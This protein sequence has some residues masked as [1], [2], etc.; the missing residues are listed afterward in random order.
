MGTWC[1][2]V[3]KDQHTNILGVLEF[4][5]YKGSIKILYFRILPSKEYLFIYRCF[6]TYRQ[7]TEHKSIQYIHQQAAAHSHYNMSTPKDKKDSR[8]LGVKLR[9]SFT[10]S[11]KPRQPV[12][13]TVTGTSA[14]QVKETRKGHI[15]VYVDTDELD[16]NANFVP[17]TSQSPS[18]RRKK[19][20]S[21]KRPRRRS[22]QSPD[23]AFF[24]SD[25][26]D[27]PPNMVK[28]QKEISKTYNYSY[29]RSGKVRENA[30]RRTSIQELNDRF[31]ADLTVSP[32]SAMDF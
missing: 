27:I 29:S 18:H 30:K 4:D 19:G 17:S 11:P 21:P 5:I 31:E 20:S 26:V 2:L 16:K 10:R 14:V 7:N 24:S 23:S 32:N 9:N 12:N 22:P 13:S 8:K 6:Q 25:D 3:I 28:N 1:M 15:S